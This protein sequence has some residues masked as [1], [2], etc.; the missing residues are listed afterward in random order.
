MEKG[1]SWISEMVLE[2]ESLPS[3]LPASAMALPSSKP[4]SV[5]LWAACGCFLLRHLDQVF[6]RSCLCADNFQEFASLWNLVSCHK[7]GGILLLYPYCRN[8]PKVYGKPECHGSPPSF[9][10]PCFV[11]TEFCS[12]EGL[13]QGE[14]R[15]TL[16]LCTYLERLKNQLHNFGTRSCR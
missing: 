15:Y 8:K 10:A 5:L 1:K 3:A 2:S 4:S 7:Q 13:T 16:F 6:P 9:A 12:S 11:S 14:R